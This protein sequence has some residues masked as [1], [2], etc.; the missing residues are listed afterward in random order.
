M[1]LCEIWST[2]CVSYGML[3]PSLAAAICNSGY[4]SA[5]FPKIQLFESEY[6]IQMSSAFFFI[7][8]KDSLKN[9]VTALWHSRRKPPTLHTQS[10]DSFGIGL[11][12]VMM[13]EAGEDFQVWVR[14]LGFGCRKHT[15]WFWM[16][17]ASDCF[18]VRFLLCHTGL[19]HLWCE[20]RNS[21]KPITVVV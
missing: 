4:R 19:T 16:N 10:Y 21:D 15:N 14:L 1:F 7:I 8:M 6:V 3:A 2:F 12:A 5:K 20:I 18:L 13:L 11:K 17:D 9:R